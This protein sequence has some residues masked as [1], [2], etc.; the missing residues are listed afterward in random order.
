MRAA[1]L[2]WRRPQIDPVEVQEI[3]G[4]EDQLP[5]RIADRLA[6]QREVGDAARVLDDDLAVDQRR[7]AVEPSGLFAELRVLVSPV[8]PVAGVGPTSPPPIAIC[9]R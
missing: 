7:L 6:Q 5:R 8:V 4:K 2:K 1:F 9:V 3:E